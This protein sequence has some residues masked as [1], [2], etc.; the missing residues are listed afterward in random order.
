MAK[1]YDLIL[2]RLITILT[3]LSNDERPNTLSLAEEFNVSTKTIQTDIYKRL[4]SFAIEKDVLGRFKFINGFSLDKSMLDNHEM[5][6]LSLALSNFSEQEK[7]SKT[8]ESIIQKLIYPYLLNP[9]YIKSNTY[10]ALHSDSIILS[11]LER[12][13]KAKNIIIIKQ[14]ENSTRVE[15]YKIAAYD[16]FWYLFAKDTKDN[17]VKTFTLSNITDVR[18]LEEYHKSDMIE[19]EKILK[20]TQSAW[21][22]DGNSYEVVIEVYTDIADYFLKRSFLQSQEI[23]EHKEN[24]SLIVKFEVTHDED[25]DNLIKS[26][27]PHIKVISPQSIKRR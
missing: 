26:W 19:I 25:I 9:Y 12:A 1:S 6:L 24:G 7:F 10:E 2:T 20:G 15:P 23:I 27:L 21:Y 5:I 3:M 17:R 13:I 4:Q 14:S 8:T 22:D 11:S 18:I 16:G